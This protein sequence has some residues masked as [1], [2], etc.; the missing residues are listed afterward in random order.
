[1]PFVLCHVNSSQ[2][3]D[4]GALAV[5]LASYNG[6]SPSSQTS[7]VVPESTW[8]K[9]SDPCDEGL[10]DGWIHVHHP[11]TVCRGQEAVGAIAAS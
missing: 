8:W 2:R 7:P 3:C 4:L 5:P 6:C 11:Q 9:W 10:V 1:M